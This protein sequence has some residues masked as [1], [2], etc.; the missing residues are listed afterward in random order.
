MKAV[1]PSVKNDQ[2]YKQHVSKVIIPINN[3]HAVVNIITYVVYV[4]SYTT[5]I[6][7]VQHKVMYFY[8]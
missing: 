6:N 1:Y 5:K 8:T 3:S 2:T 4:R 7:Y